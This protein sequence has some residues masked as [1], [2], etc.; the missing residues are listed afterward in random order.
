MNKSNSKSRYNP[1]I[2]HRWEIFIWLYIL[3]GSTLETR[4]NRNARWDITYEGLR[5]NVKSAKLR[6][7]AHGKYFRWKLDQGR[8]NCDFFVLVGYGKRRD[9]APLRIYIIAA[10]YWEKTYLFAGPN[11]QGHLKQFEREVPVIPIKGAAAI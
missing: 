2:G 6:Q 1:E 11:H 8:E 9:R 4:K 5:F 7:Y 3:I 10:D